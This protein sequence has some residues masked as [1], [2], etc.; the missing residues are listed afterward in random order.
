MRIDP[1]VTKGGEGRLFLLTRELRQL[2]DAQSEGRASEELVYPVY[3]EAQ[4]GILNALEV[5]KVDSQLIMGGNSA[6]LL[7]LDW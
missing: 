2:I 6:R 7:R 1:G 5:S 4:L 3:E